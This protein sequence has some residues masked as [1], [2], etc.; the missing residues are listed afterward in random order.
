MSKLLKLV[1]KGTTVTLP[2]SVQQG[3]VSLK[4]NVTFEKQALNK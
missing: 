1:P 4:V 3:M 2:P